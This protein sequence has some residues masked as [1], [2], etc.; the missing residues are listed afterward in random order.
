MLMNYL[1]I[2]VFIAL[3]IL[4]GIVPLVAGMILRPKDPYQAKD[5]PYECG[6]SPFE[7]ARLPFDVKFYLV[8]ILF[9]IFDLET[10]F[11][12][13]WAV[14]LHKLGWF[15]IAAMGI[16]VGLLIIGFIYE[17]KKGALEWE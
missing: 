6:F 3:G 14:V 12:F 15:G 4:F 13:P 1:P 7:D 11:L 2:L 10:A 8:A 9:I 17:W 5:A 16:F